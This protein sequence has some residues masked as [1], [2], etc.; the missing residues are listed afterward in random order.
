MTDST[1]GS[2]GDDTE[3]I[4]SPETKIVTNSAIRTLIKNARIPVH[5]IYEGK[6][7]FKMIPRFSYFDATATSITLNNSCNFAFIYRLKDKTDEIT[8]DDRFTVG[9]SYDMID[10]DTLPWKLELRKLPGKRRDFQKLHMNALKHAEYIE[11][12]N[13]SRISNLSKQQ[14][15]D[16][17]KD[18]YLETF[19]CPHAGENEIGSSNSN[20]GN[21][22]RQP[23]A[24]RIHFSDGTS[25]VRKMDKKDS[26][27][28]I[29]QGIL[30]SHVRAGDIPY[31]KNVDNWL[32]ICFPNAKANVPQCINSRKITI[33]F[34]SVGS[35]PMIIQNIIRISSVSTI[36]FCNEYV[37]KK[38]GKS[39]A[40]GT[41]LY[42][43]L[44]GLFLV[45]DKE[46]LYNLCFEN[47][48]KISLYYSDGEA[49]V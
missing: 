17:Q 30:V 46:T 18:I 28:G 13:I 41:K 11:K 37:L 8:C 21:K 25:L 9:I 10:P 3:D 36:S 2:S 7:Y 47:C 40:D 15:Q 23:I 29:I 44:D 20:K 38:L 35:T 12:G 49:W 1:A 5:I 16:I 22:K 34:R 14:Y 48:D 42:F 32:H 26:V 39:V 33:T 19:D 24:T 31:M 45:D 6:D 27:Y 43:Y 4:F